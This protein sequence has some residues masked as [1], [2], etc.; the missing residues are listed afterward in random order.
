[1]F[2]YNY[3]VKNK[4][5]TFDIWDVPGNEYSTEHDLVFSGAHVF[6]L[7]FDVTRKVSYTNL[8][9]WYDQMRRLRPHIPCI[10]LANKVDLNE[11]AN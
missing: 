10:C 4:V 8:R 9:H 11:R 6:I 1:M 5:T 7:V 3:T 2:R